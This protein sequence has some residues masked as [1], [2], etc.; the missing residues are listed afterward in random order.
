METFRGFGAKTD[1]YQVNKGN[2]VVHAIFGND[3][4]LPTVTVYNHMDVQPAS[5]ETEPWNT[6]PFVMTKQGDSYF[7]R[8]TTDDKGPG[9]AALYGAR[10]ALEANIP[11][12]IRFLGNSKKNGSPNFERIIAKPR[13]TCAPTRSL[14]PIPFGYHAIARKLCG[15]AWIDGFL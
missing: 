6:E 8:G 2:P 14:S 9:L 7:G 1:V 15:L 12:N 10:A 3:A 13:A 5:K 11:V 4:K